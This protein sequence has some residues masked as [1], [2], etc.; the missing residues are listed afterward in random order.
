M[1]YLVKPSKPKKKTFNRED[2]QKIYQSSKWKQLRISKLMSNP[3]CQKCLQKG[4]TTLAI[5]VH[6]IDSF[7][8]YTGLMRLQKA[9]DI[10]NLVSLCKECHAL[11]HL[12][13]TTHG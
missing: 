13:G 10:D 3:L 4:K 1:P 2:R 5:D 11:E 9:Y 7:M 8:N 6:H 12:N